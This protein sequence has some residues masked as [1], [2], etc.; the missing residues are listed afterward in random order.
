[1]EQF[2]VIE[3]AFAGEGKKEKENKQTKNP[4]R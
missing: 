1:V 3:R 4:Q 2:S